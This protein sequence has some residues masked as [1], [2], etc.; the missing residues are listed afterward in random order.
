MK[1][2]KPIETLKK[3]IV[4]LSVFIVFKAI[5]AIYAYA[6]GER[7]GYLPHLRLLTVV[8]LG[9]LSY[10]AIQGKKAAQWLIAICLL[11]QIIAVFWAIF[12]V[13]TTQPM[14]KVIAIVL[15]IYFVF[16]GWV[17]AEL[18]KSKNEA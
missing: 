2:I 1:M 9:T 14:F 8:L 13:P 16:G 4:I 5:Q 15:S 11:G 6:V 17:L 10:L 12:I 3:P 18:A 7:L